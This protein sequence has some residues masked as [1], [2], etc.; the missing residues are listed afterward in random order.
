MCIIYWGI[1]DDIPLS[2]VL[3]TSSTQDTIDLKNKIP[4]LSD[5]EPTYRSR[6]ASQGLPPRSP[7]R[8]CPPTVLKSIPVLLP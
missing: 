3:E 1:S 2:A 6:Y 5:L 7:L 4:T 8:A